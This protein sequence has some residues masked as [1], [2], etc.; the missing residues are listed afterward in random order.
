MRRRAIEWAKSAAIVLLL[1]SAAMLTLTAVSYSGAKTP[2]FTMLATYLQ[3]ASDQPPRKAESPALTDASLP[4]L[5]SV[6]TDAGRASFWGA[7]GER[8]SVY[9]TLGGFLAEA[10]G[11]AAAPARASEADFREAALGEGVYFR[12]PGEIPLPVLGAWLDASCN[13]PVSADRFILSTGGGTVRLLAAGADGVYL[14]E[15]RAATETLR[16]ALLTYPDDGS[17]LAAEMDGPCARLD[18][19][20]L[21]DASVTGLAAGQASNPCD[22]TFLTAAAA[23]LGFN[24]Y[25]DGSY[26]DAAGGVVFPESDCTLRFGGDGEMLLRNQ[27]LVSRFSAAG[28]S[29]GAC[30]EYARA[31][32]E[33]VSDG[34]LG[35]A[36]LQF[37]ALR[38]EDS[39][40]LVTFSYVLGG[41]PLSMGGEAAAEARFTGTVLSELRFH[42]R[43]YTLSQ[44]EWISLLPPAQAA[45]VLPDG[46]LLELA[47]ADQGDGA[48]A[49]GW[50][51]E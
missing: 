14:M 15:T 31:L 34:W 4:L 10:L 46:A 27:A 33:A 39:Q 21:I 40:T 23:A 45:P 32:L 24:P 38:R 28:N 48:L 11:T 36:S 3:G 12:F 49:A 18:P 26:R 51:L 43:S 6:H 9:E 41:L 22:G 37:T 16:G 2:P 42:V 35:D 44:T 29:D 5:I 17:R 19:L 47:Y 20:S 25:G 7:L 8:E 50:L 1:L 13:A 30:V